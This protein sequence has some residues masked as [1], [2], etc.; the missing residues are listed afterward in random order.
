MNKNKGFLGIGL[1][2][3]IIVVLSVGGIAYYVG[4]KNNSV[5]KNIEEARNQFQQVKPNKL[6]LEV[7]GYGFTAGDIIQAKTEQPVVGD[8]IIYDSFKNDSICFTM[9]S[10]KYLGKILGVPG[11]TFSFQNGNLKIRT[12]IVKFDKDYSKERAVFGG[13]KY[14]NLVDKNIT[15][16]PREYLIDK[17][18]GL[19]CFTG[20][21]DKTGSSISYNRFTINKEAI[22]GV[23]GKKIGHDNKAENE[24]RS[25]IY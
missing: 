17:W 11:E 21:L 18:M 2:I 1:I 8:V 4:I 20:E 6:T 3:A 10:G 15:L 16:Q 23:I 5:P 25:R 14:E 13:Q 22:I 12:E 7:D 9:G 19:E 24:F